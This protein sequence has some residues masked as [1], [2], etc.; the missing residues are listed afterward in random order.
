MQS[1]EIESKRLFYGIQAA[2]G[3]VDRPAKNG[4]HEASTATGRVDR[5]A[6]RV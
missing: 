5:D 6:G 3:T 4:L 2:I 1:R